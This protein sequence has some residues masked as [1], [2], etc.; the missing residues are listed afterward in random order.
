MPE[1]QRCR[2][3]SSISTCL[4][5]PDEVERIVCGLRPTNHPGAES[6]VSRGDGR[7]DHGGRH[8]ASDRSQSA[9]DACDP[10]QGTARARLVRL[11][12]RAGRD[13]PRGDERGD[14][15]ATR[16]GHR[17][18]HQARPRQVVGRRTAVSNDPRFLVR[19]SR[20]PIVIT[21]ANDV[22]VFYQCIMDG[23]S[24]E[25]TRVFEEPTVE[26]ALEA[27]HDELVIDR[28]LGLPIRY[29]SGFML[30]S[31]SISPYGWDRPQAFGHVGMSN[32]FTWADRDRDLVVAMLTTGKPVIGP[33]L[34]PLVKLLTGINEA[35][36]EAHVTCHLALPARRRRAH[37]DWQS[38]GGSHAVQRDPH[39][40]TIR[41]TRCLPHWSTSRRSSRNTKRSARAMC[42]S[43]DVT[44]ATMARS[45]W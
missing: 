39:L 12:R 37:D 16:A 40:S 18:V 32:L 3:K 30:G 17:T 31:D 19:S 9:R 15:S 35:V 43:F 21:T 33:H 27:P 20:R 38:R 13:R 26:R 44:K 2:P 14:R 25:G 36:P 29:G 22:A 24:F 7:P 10:H 28:M 42:S 45:P 5:D 1:S 11:R 23:G 4:S 8:P 34:L 41:P 6:G